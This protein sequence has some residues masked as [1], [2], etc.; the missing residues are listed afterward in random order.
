MLGSDTTQGIRKKLYQEIIKQVT[1]GHNIAADRRAG[2]SNPHIHPNLSNTLKNMQ[3]VFKN[4]DGPRYQ[5]IGG[6]R[7]KELRV[8]N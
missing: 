7:L 3:I 5:W 2:V 1:W 8:R 6:Q 4:A